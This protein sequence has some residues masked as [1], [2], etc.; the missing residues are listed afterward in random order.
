MK[1]MTDTD[2]VLKLEPENIKGILLYEPRHEKTCLPG[3]RIALM[4][5]RLYS[6]RSGLKFQI[7]VEE[8][9]Y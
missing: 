2:R 8:G 7:K 9:L 3:L 1:A 4:Q 6:H 5:T